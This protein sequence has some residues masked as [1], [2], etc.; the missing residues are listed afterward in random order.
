MEH[1]HPADTVDVQEML[2]DLLEDNL[3]GML[4]ARMDEKLRYS[5]YD[6]RNKETDD[7]RNSY[8]KNQF[9]NRASSV[10]SLSVSTACAEMV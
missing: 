1:Y 8:G 9:V 6:Y 3:Q 7:S 5:K 2:K 10:R 4:E